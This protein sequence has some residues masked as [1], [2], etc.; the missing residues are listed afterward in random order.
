MGWL[1]IHFRFVIEH[2]VSVLRGRAARQVSLKLTNVNT[3]QALVTSI[4]KLLHFSTLMNE[5]EYPASR[6]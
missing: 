4:W 2:T 5:L 6:R 3:P 1:A